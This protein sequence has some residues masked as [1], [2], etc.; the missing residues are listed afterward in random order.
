MQTSKARRWFLTINNYTDDDLEGM[1]ALDYKY[2]LIAAE[3]GPKEGTPH[4][5]AMVIFQNEFR[6]NRLKQLVPRA[7]LEVV[8]G[9]FKQAYSYITK[10][11][12]ILFENGDKPTNPGI[13]DTFKQMV[14]DAKAGTID[15]ECLMYCRYE[16]FFQRFMPKEEWHFDGDL[17]TKNVWIYGPPGT[18]KSTFVREFAKS[19]GYRIYE[20]LSNKWWDNFDNEEIVLME[21]LDPKVCE[22]LIHHIKLWADRWPFRAEIKGGSVRIMPKFMLFVTSNYSI[23]ECFQGIDGTAIARRFQ[24]KEKTEGTTLLL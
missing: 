19:N 7:N 6:F 24:E 18:G 17:P 1:K 8:R 12:K 2:L 10:D 14:Q 5:H 20:K 3:V 11:G 13:G 15:Q 9:T 21:D 23:A 16:R 4:V 22:V